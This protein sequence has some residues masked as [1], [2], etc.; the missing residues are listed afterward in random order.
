MEGINPKTLND[1]IRLRKCL[2]L[3]KYAPGIPDE[4]IKEIYDFLKNP[5]CKVI[6]TPEMLYF[7]YINKAVKAF[8]VTPSMLGQHYDRI[9]L[10]THI[11]NITTF[12]SGSSSSSGCGGC[13]GF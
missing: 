12:T 13:S 5:R 3:K 11:Y 10:S 6:L 7:I 8:V 9:E 4:K 1:K 2:K